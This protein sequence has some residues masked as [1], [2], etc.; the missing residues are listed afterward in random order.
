M[1]EVRRQGVMREEGHAEAGL[2]AFLDRGGGSEAGGHP[3]SVQAPAAGLPEVILQRPLCAGAFLPQDERLVAEVLHRDLLPSGPG[4]IGPHR[5]HELVLPQDLVNQ[6]AVP[7]PRSDDAQLVTPVQHPLVDA[8]RVGDLET[9]G[10][11]GE[12]LV[13]TPEHGGEEVLPGDRAAAQAE[14]PLLD[15]EEV[16]HV[17]ADRALHV[18]ERKGLPVEPLTGPGRHHPATQ[19][20]QQARADDALQVGHPLA[21]GGLYQ[22]NLRGGLREA[23]HFHDL[24]KNLELAE[25]EVDT[26]VRV[27]SRP[28]Q[29]ITSS[30]SQEAPVVC[31]ACPVSCGRREPSVFLVPQDV[32]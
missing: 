3:E 9:N 29:R 12:P 18:Q 31:M 14:L 17:Q 16:L 8:Y 7:A 6:A 4:V 32:L 25:V 22:V 23:L 11:R 2:H 15:A 24:A 19:A 10:H 5:Q 20:I 13:E 28:S 27:G 26:A 30:A 21:H 1:S